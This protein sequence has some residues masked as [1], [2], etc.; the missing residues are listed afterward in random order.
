MDN[1]IPYFG[2]FGTIHIK[3]GQ[4]ETINQQNKQNDAQDEYSPQR[5]STKEGGEGGGRYG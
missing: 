2:P 1:A 5:T 3:N 4:V